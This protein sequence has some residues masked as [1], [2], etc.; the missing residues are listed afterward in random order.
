MDGFKL[1]KNVDQ[2]ERR[3]GKPILLLNSEKQFI[4]ELC[5]NIITVAAEL[6]VTWAIITPKTQCGNSKLKKI[7]LA[8]IYNTE[9]TPKAKFVDI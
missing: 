2:R 6:E 9:K 7:V 1:G 5:P 3:G 4:T 8:S